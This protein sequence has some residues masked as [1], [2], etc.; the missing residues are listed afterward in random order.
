MTQTKLFTVVASYC[1]VSGRF[2]VTFAWILIPMN[3]CWVSE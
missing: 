3:V 1:L 2:Y